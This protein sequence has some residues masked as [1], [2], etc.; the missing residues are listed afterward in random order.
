METGDVEYIHFSGKGIYRMDSNGRDPLGKC[1]LR[2]IGAKPAP[3][4]MLDFR[5][6]SL[7][8]IL[9]VFIPSPAKYERTNPCYRKIQAVTVFS[10]QSRKAC[11]F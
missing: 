6:V 2:L 1:L 5:A 11:F 10:T 7:S 8:Y 9:V 4:N 3:W